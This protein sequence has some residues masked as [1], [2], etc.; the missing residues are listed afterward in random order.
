MAALSKR[1]YCFPNIKIMSQ[2]NSILKLLIAGL[3]RLSILTAIFLGSCAGSGAL[4]IH[5]PKWDLEQVDLEQDNKFFGAYLTQGEDAVKVVLHRYL[6]EPDSYPRTIFRMPHDQISHAWDG[7]GNATI[8]AED[9]PDGSQL[10]QI[11]A[12]GDTPWVS[13]SEYRV[14]DNQ[15]YPLRHGAANQLFLL[16]ALLSPF[17]TWI[18]RKP[19][20]RVVT[21]LVGTDKPSHG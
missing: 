17:I 11:H 14:T 13:L 20:S 15:I 16:S 19:V 5:S 1:A 10:I 2:D 4:Y 21:L 9:Q 18:A 12:V 8:T 6:P 7:G 3:L